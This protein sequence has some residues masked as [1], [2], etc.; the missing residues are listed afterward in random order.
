MAIGRTLSPSVMVTGIVERLQ[1]QTKKSD[2]VVYAHDVT[3]VDQDGGRLAVRIWERSGEDNVQV[4]TIGSFLGVIATVS[5]RRDPETPGKVYTELH[6]RRYITPGD[7]D[8]I[9]SRMF[10]PAKG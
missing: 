1:A 2:G 9:N 10:T 4:P 7:L 5:E 6:A 3:L 8:A